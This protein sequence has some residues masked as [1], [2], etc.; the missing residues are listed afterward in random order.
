MQPATEQQIN[1]VFFMLPREEMLLNTE[2]PATQS[3][4]QSAAQNDYSQDTTAFD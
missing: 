4:S 1:T 3:C 2:A